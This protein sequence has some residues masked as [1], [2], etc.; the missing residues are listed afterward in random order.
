LVCDAQNVAHPSLCEF[1]GAPNLTGKG[2]CDK[3]YEVVSTR[4]E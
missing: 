2:S 4:C 1:A 3:I